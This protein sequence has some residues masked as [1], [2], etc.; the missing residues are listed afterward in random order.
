MKAGGA[1][2]FKGNESRAARRF[3]QCRPQRIHHGEKGGDQVPIAQD[4][5]RTPPALPL[6]AA[7]TATNGESARVNHEHFNKR[8]RRTCQRPQSLIINLKHLPTNGQQKPSR[9]SQVSLGWSGL[10]SASSLEMYGS[11]QAQV[12]TV[13]MD[14][15][16]A[17]GLGWKE[18]DL[19]EVGVVRQATKG[20]SVSVTPATSDDWEVLVSPGKPPLSRTVSLMSHRNCTRGTWKTICC[21]S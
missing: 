16:V 10:A 19:V 4:Q 13:E 21:R 14:P 9:A 12:E 7:R 2:S 11:G 8:L 18:G 20:R 3:L 5:P 6:C 17:S 15:E 1:E